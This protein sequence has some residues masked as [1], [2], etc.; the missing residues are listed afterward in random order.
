MMRGGAVYDDGMLRIAWAGDPPVL[1]IA[2]EIDE[3]TYPGLVGALKE[4]QDGYGEVHI[5]LAEVDYCDLAGLRAI[6][7]LTGTDGQGPGADGQDLSTDGQRP[8]ENGQ[9]RYRD[10]LGRGGE[11]RH[12][13]RVVLH[14]VPSQLLTVLRIVGWDTAPGLALADGDARSQSRSKASTE[15]SMLGG[16]RG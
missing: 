1:N 5:S 6:V 4:V 2:G 11:E 14:E 15:A 12:P 16:G 3:S 9:G 7:L 8:S 10:G 13:R